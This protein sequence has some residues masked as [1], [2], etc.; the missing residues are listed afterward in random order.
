MEYKHTNDCWAQI[1]NAKTKAEVA[2]L[3]MEFPRWSGDWELTVEG[4]HYLVI[5][6][7]YDQQYENYENNAEVLDIELDEEDLEDDEFYEDLPTVS[8]AKYQVWLLGYKFNPE[9][10]IEVDDFTQFVGE[11]DSLAEAKMLATSIKNTRLELTTT[12]DIVMVQVQAVVE[13]E[14]HG[15]LCIGVDYEAQVEFLK[16]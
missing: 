16:K 12:S 6:T 14:D 3:F 8:T 15:E 1:K 7:Y 5:N 4:D 10:D 2:K 13:V 9:G 11:C